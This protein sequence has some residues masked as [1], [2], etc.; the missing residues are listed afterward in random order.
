MRFIVDFVNKHPSNF[1]KLY[2][3][4]NHRYCGFFILPYYLIPEFR[5]ALQKIL[6]RGMST[7]AS[8][9][10]LSNE[11][12][13]E[14]GSI[15]HSTPPECFARND[16]TKARG[17]THSDQNQG[18]M[19]IERKK[20]IGDNMLVTWTALDRLDEETISLEL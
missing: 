5:L 1:Y 11:Q 17:N 12:P 2:N 3:T 10:L 15:L 4:P 19:S 18:V 9:L 7:I 20:T 8:R 14:I 16:Q 13:I 6:E